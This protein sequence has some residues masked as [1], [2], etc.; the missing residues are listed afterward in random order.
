MVVWEAALH[1]LTLLRC[2]RTLSG[3]ASADSGAR[4]GACEGDATHG[5]DQTPLEASSA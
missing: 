4:R 3:A 1:E 2:G 5:L